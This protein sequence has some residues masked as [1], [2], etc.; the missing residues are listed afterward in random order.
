MKQRIAEEPWFHN[1]IGG[2]RRKTVY[3][4]ERSGLLLENYNKLN[5]KWGINVVY[6]LNQRREIIRLIEKEHSDHDDV[7]KVLEWK[8]D[9]GTDL[10][11]INGVFR[12][13]EV[14]GEDVGAELVDYIILEET[15]EYENDP[16]DFLRRCISSLKKEGK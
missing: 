5:E 13:A 3:R 14:Y 15:L 4:N 1:R 2:F 10:F 6:R 11:G 7:I 9:I 12:N 8:K 16:Y